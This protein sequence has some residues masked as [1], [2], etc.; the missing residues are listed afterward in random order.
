MIR[1]F[2]APLGAALIILVASAVP[3]AAGYGHIRDG[4]IFGIN[5]G[6]GWTRVTFTAGVEGADEEGE[7]DTEDTFGGMVHWGFAPS[8]QFIYGLGIGGWKKQFGDDT[9]SLLYFDATGTWFVRGEGLFLRGGVGYGNVDLTLRTFDFSLV[10]V[11][12]G[13]LSLSAG[14][15]YE[16][17][18]QPEFALG[19][20][21]DAH[22]T[23]VG[24]MAALRD[25]KVVNYNLSLSF[26]YY[27]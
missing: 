20:A 4:H 27:L 7:T 16:F 18:L 3:S 22:W 9:V 5:P 2:M 8:D 13:G 26:R 15:G 24:E 1:R 21:F 19:V 17:R 23:N 10:S 25:V 14:A 6:W 12:K 11:Q